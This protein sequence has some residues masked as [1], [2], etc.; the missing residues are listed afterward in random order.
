MSPRKRIRCTRVCRCVPSAMVDYENAH[1][2]AGRAFTPGDEGREMATVDQQFTLE[3]LELAVKRGVMQWWAAPRPN[4]ACAVCRGPNGM[5][6]MPNAPHLAGQPAFYRVEQLKNY[7]GGKRPHEVMGVIAGTPE[8]RRDRGSRRLLFVAADQRSSSQRPQT[9]PFMQLQRR[10]F[11]KFSP[12]R[13]IS[14]V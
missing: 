3:R 5:S 14:S 9:P 1:V 13:P 12:C 11:L 7:R 6:M 8:R 2:V 10:V 4:M